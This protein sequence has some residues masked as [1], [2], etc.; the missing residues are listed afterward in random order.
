[1]DYAVGDTVGF[2]S[3]HRHG[4]ILSH[5]FGIITKIN[6]HG[7]IHITQNGGN[8]KKFDKHGQSYKDNYGPRLI[9]AATLTEIIERNANSRNI[10]H[11]TQDITRAIQSR[12]CG[13]GKNAM[14]AETLD[15]IQI[16]ITKLRDMVA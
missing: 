1:M 7:H 15:E 4:T 2:A 12:Q 16:L 11:A 10:T 14:T 9:G 5:G 13:N 8:E 3:F 6:G